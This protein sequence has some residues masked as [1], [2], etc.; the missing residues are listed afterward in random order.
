M[1]CFVPFMQAINSDHVDVILVSP[2][3][4]ANEDFINRIFVSATGNRVGLLV[5]DEAH[6]ISVW[7]HDFRPDYRRLIDTVAKLPVTLRVLGT[8]ATA[9]DR[10]VSDIRQ[11]LGD[12]V[13][14]QRGSLL[15]ETLHLQNITMP[16][17]PSRLAWLAENIPRLPGSGI[18][19]VLRKLDA[20]Q[21]TEWLRS[22]GINARAYYAGVAPSREFPNE[23][24]EV[25][26]YRQ[27]LEQLLIDNR[28]KVLVATVA[29]GM[30]FDKS[31]IGFVVHYQV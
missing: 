2:E 21:I 13:D 3:R 1:H 9:T 12:D 20:D 25:D 22:R 29:L 17:H 31:D 10:V 6:C 27:Y 16:N 15:R 8:T 4:L 23:I 26:E 19:Y 11:I 18:V 5:V 14:V 28:I 24:A 30:G 7:G